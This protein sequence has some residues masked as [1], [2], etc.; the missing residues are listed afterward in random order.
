MYTVQFY[1]ES[2]DDLIKEYERT[3]KTL[4]NAMKYAKLFAIDNNHSAYISQGIEESKEL[5]YGIHHNSVTEF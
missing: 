1:Y 4:N 2:K 3:Y 5:I